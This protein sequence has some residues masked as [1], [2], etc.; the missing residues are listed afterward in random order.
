M[1]IN[2]VILFEIAIL[3][4]ITKRAICNLIFSLNI[5]VHK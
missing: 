2:K 3:V 1:T 4:L 5:K